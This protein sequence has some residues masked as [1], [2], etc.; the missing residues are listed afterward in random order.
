M[1]IAA[2]PLSIPLNTTSQLHAL[3]WF[4][5]KLFSDMGSSFSKAVTLA[6]L[7]NTALM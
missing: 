5:V 4:L 3:L 2:E 7:T 6:F 1:V